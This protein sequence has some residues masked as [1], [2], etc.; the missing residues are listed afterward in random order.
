MTN[1][2]IL[3][4]RSNGTIKWVISLADLPGA[5]H[6]NMSKTAAKSMADAL[7]RLVEGQQTAVKFPISLDK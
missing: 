7:N 1:E 5:I 6:L 2:I 4:K 3:R